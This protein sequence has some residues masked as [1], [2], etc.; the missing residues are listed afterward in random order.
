MVLT[1]ADA[2]GPEVPALAEVTVAEVDPGPRRVVTSAPGGGAST[3]CSQRIGRRTVALIGESGAGKSTLVNALVAG[4]DVAADG[5][6]RAGDSKGR[7]TTTS[8]ELH[9]L[10]SG[11]VLVDTPGIREVGIFVDPEAVAESFPDIEELA[12]RCR[13]RDCVHAAEPG[14]AVLAAV[15]AGELAAERWEAWQALRKEAES[16]ALRADAHAQ[17]QAD[18]RFGRMV[19]ES[20]RHKRP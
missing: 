14:C 12:E 6:V 13:F 5:A 7:H 3:T 17:H 2:V 11:G 20:E 1:K 9:L 15:E 19:R 10:P 4:D 8:R 18:R 16:A